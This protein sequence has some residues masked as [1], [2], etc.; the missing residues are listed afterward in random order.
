VLSENL[1]E[2]TTQLQDEW[3]SSLTQLADLRNELQDAEI[4][5]KELQQQSEA[6]EQEISHL[7]EALAR[8]L[9]DTAADLA[10]GVDD[11]DGSTLKA[12]SNF[13]I[14]D[15]LLLLRTRSDLTFIQQP[16]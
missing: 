9:R 5:Q 11:P 15:R 6:Q 4:K 7:K 3:E 10:A 14:A 1:T 13:Y 8:A 2:L 16:H 12:H